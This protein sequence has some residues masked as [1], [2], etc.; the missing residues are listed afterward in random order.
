[1]RQE[2]IKEYFLAAGPSEEQ[3]NRMLAGV[4]EQCEAREPLN[5]LSGS[6][7]SGG[8]CADKGEKTMN[9]S[10]KKRISS[11]AAMAA[12]MVL[13]TVSAFA[14]VPEF[15]DWIGEQFGL[16]AEQEQ[17]LS[18]SGALQN[19][20]ATATD[21]VRTLT[22][23]QTM[24]DQNGMYIV[25]DIDSVDGSAVEAELDDFSFQAPGAADVFLFSYEQQVLETRENG[26]TCMAVLSGLENLNGQ[27]VYLTSCGLTAEWNV[28]DVAPMA[29]HKADLWGKDVWTGLDYHVT[30]Y[31]ISPICVKLDLEML[32]SLNGAGMPDQVTVETV[33]ADGS[34]KTI[35]ADRS[36]GKEMD[37]E[38]Y[39]M[40]LLDEIIDVDAVHAVYVDGAGLK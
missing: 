32:S 26:V 31:S 19:V 14:A 21:G 2:D 4:L 18:Q 13:T 40:F 11:I 37:G 7:D 12:V 8:A 25:Y 33:Q 20:E 17:A 30:G 24:A 36:F 10:M 27:Q 5:V 38:R 16:T 29:V 34:V 22:V 9:V 35:K 23:R 39:Q 15:R 3:K 28:G 1:M 6:P